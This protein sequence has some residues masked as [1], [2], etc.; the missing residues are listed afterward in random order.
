MIESNVKI[1]E[2]NH[3]ERLRLNIQQSLLSALMSSRC[4]FSS[5]ACRNSF[6]NIGKS[7]SSSS[8]RDCDRSDAVRRMN[9]STVEQNAQSIMHV[10]LNSS[11][12]KMLLTLRSE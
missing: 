11:S 3:I 9:K 7:D 6:S 4:T 12:T 5:S 8:C 1:R 2:N 10:I